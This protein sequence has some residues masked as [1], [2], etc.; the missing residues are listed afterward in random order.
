MRNYRRLFG[1]WRKNW[2]LAET[3]CETFAERS[4]LQES[5]CHDSA[6]CHTAHPV[7]RRLFK[8]QIT[9]LEL[10]RETFFKFNGRTVSL[11]RSHFEFTPT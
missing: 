5:L 2:T 6:P 7:K 9:V 1:R 8:N 10:R 3:L 4:D 11:K